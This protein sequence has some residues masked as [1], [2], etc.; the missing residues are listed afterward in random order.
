MARATPARRSALRNL[1]HELYRL[2]DNKSAVAILLWI[3]GVALVLV[4][5]AGIVLPA[6]PGTILIFAGLLLAAWANGFTAV[7]SGPL[8]LIGVIAAVSYAVDLVA[9]AAGA[10]RIGSSRRAVVGAA[11][12]TLLGLFF[13]L[14]G[15]LFGPL[16]GALVAEWTVHRDVRRAG[17]AG[18]GAWIGFLVGTGVKIAL[19]FSMIAIFILAL[20]W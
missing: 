19:A 20:F 2:D 7:G 12:G 4:G 10:Q 8:I 11:L 5:L 16:A 13:G 15:V 1:T 18:L 3:V 14:P 17:R 6:L 9:A